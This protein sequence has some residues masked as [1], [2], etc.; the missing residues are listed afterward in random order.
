MLISD[1]KCL[2]MLN[3]SVRCDIQ[4]QSTVSV[5]MS[6]TAVRIL[7]H[8]GALKCKLTG[9]V[10]TLST[11]AGTSEITAQQYRYVP[12]KLQSSLENSLL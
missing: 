12:C 6:G 8:H 9:I 11:P 4:V 10:G 3:T 1:V 2:M 7:V 5:R